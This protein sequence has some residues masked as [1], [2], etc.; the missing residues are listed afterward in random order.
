MQAGRA[1]DDVMIQPLQVAFP[2]PQLAAI[3]LQFL[4]QASQGLPPFPV[5]GCYVDP[6]IQQQPQKRPVAYAN[7]DY[8]HMFPLQRLQIVL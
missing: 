6:R 5:T 8:R 1:E 2:Q 7:T 4:R 3:R